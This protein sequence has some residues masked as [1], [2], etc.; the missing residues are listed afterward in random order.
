LPA[1]EVIH[2]L[3]FVKR[4]DWP[5]REA[6]ALRRERSSLALDRPRTRDSIVVTTREHNGSESRRKE[7]ADRPK[8]G[9]LVDRTLAK[10]Q[11]TRGQPRDRQRLEKPSVAL[12]QATPHTRSYHDLC[13]TPILTSRPYPSLPR[14]PSERVP[15][16]TSQH[17][18]SSDFAAPSILSPPSVS[19]HVRTSEVT[20]SRSPTPVRTVPQLP[21]HPRYRDPVTT[22][23][24]W[25]TEDESAWESASI[26][27]YVPRFSLG[28]PGHLRDQDHRSL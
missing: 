1:T 18:P 19:N 8:D 7:R 28:Y 9:G 25:S 15:I 21:P 11:D 5:E 2:P 17:R 12:S 10:E 22:P 24:P 23:S 14:S 16:P 20:H 6:A 13:L 26:T 27:L 3:E 4:A